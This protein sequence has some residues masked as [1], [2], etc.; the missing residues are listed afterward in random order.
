VEP[1][2]PLT[3]QEWQAIWSAGIDFGYGPCRDLLP[4]ERWN[5]PWLVPRLVV[6]IEP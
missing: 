1:T 3:A 5:A 2:G 4:P 6:R